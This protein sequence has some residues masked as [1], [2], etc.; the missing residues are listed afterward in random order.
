MTLTKIG[1]RVRQRREEQGLDQ[2]QLAAIV[3]K[4]RGYISRVETGKAGEKAEDLIA[5]ARALGTTLADLVGETDDALLAEVRRRLPDGTELALSFERLA[6][7]LPDQPEQDQEFIRRSIKALA[8]R[9]GV[10]VDPE[11]ETGDQT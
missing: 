5:I 4:T 8:E 2:G 9:Y 1:Q 6:R 11:S 10:P 7:A 3:G